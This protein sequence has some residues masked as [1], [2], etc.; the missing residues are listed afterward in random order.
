MSNYFADG[1]GTKLYIVGVLTSIV[2]F[3]LLSQQT[4]E[5]VMPPKAGRAISDMLTIS[6]YSNEAT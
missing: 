3:P 2:I 1:G 6:D 5:S 4:S